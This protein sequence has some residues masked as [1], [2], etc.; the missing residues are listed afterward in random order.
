MKDSVVGALAPVLLGVVTL[1]L[2]WFALRKDEKWSFSEMVEAYPELEWVG[3][4]SWIFLTLWF[5]ASGIFLWVSLKE[6]DRQVYNSAGILLAILAV[7]NGLFA[8][9]SG[10]CHMALPR[11]YLYVYGEKVR[12]IGFIQACL[13]IALIVGIILVGI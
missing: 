10:V 13:G 5:I 1:Y 7:Y 4:A 3:V 11:R 8:F 6:P 9:F 2:P 12:P